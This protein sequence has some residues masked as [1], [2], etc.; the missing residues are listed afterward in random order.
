MASTD[1]DG[2]LRGVVAVGA[3]ARGVEAWTRFA[4]GLPPD[5]PYAIAIVLHMPANAP[6]V[7]AKII[8]RNGPLPAVSAS[9][10][11]ALQA[12]VIH[13]G[14]PDRHLLIAD[15]RSVLSEGPT[16][17]GY[18]PAINALF[19]SAALSFG[20]RS[21]GV[22]LS[23]VLDDGVVGAAAIRAMGGTTVVQQRGDALYPAMPMNAIRAGVVDHQVAAGE[24]G[25]VLA[26]LTETE[27]DAR[28]MEPDENIALE[29]RIAMGRRFSTTAD[30]D[31]LG[32]HSRYTCP[33]CNGSLMTVSEG[34]Y[35]C[36]VGHAWTADALLDA[37]DD[38]VDGALWVALRSLQ[39][40]ARLSRTL[41]ENAGSGTLF[42]RYSQVADEAERALTI[43]GKRL[44]I[45]GSVAGEHGG[46]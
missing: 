42:K 30:A 1:L 13:V 7:L 2:A 31:K 32:P 26:K 37:R 5:L 3:S 8:D 29:N 24:V 41:A 12:G 18:R 43:L 6:S 20:P 21:I 40:K 44:S 36:R 14:V 33:D 16:E 45:A 4:A 22:L 39:E 9:N 15:R 28:H 19:R 34:N 38:E 17:N 35:R 46:G 23:G 25:A 11:A 27:V 10:G